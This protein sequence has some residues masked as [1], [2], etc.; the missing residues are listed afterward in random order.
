MNPIRRITVTLAGLAAGLAFSTPAP[1]ALA[2]RVPPPGAD[3][4][5][6]GRGPHQQSPSV[7]A[8][9]PQ[10]GKAWEHRRKVGGVGPAVGGWCLLAQAD[11]YAIRTTP[12][13]LQAG[14]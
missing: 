7:A 5:Q 6:A 11:R 1:L 4:P 2:A 10:A 3:A 14:R 9:Q 8:A 13:N 12:H